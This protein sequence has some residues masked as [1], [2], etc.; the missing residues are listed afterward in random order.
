MSLSIDIYIYKIDKYLP[1]IIIIKKNHIK[2]G[3]IV[4]YY[5]QY[6]LSIIWR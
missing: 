6:T 2:N 1:T 5:K 4:K 3:S